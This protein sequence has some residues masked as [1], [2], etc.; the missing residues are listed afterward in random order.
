MN[1]KFII[2][3]GIDNVGKTTLSI[4][5]SNMIE[6][7]VYVKTPVEPYLAKCKKFDLYNEGNFSKRLDLFIEGM[8]YSSKI[9]QQYKDMGKTVVVDRWIW[10][11]FAYHFAQDNEL[12]ECWKN[13]WRKIES[14]LIQPDASYFIVVSN[15]TEWIRRQKNKKLSIVDTQLI[16]NINLRHK[17]IDF[18]LELNPKFE[19]IDNSGSVCDTVK[20][21]VASLKF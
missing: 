15:T 11:T 20:K 1:G 10:T 2:L 7:A 13:N 6:N 9:I 14:K 3:E 21:I 5:L 17:I 12:Y 8:L 4:K 16:E 18:F 19:V